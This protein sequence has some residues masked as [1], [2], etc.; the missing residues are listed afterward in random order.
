MPPFLMLQNCFV[1]CEILGGALNGMVH[2]HS[3]LMHNLQ[4]PIIHLSNLISVLRLYVNQHPFAI[5]DGL[6][7][8]F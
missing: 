3:V 7:I 2:S 6:E 4:R 5:G 1:V 8:S